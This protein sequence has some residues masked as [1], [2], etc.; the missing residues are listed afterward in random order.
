MI[1]NFFKILRPS[2]LFITAI[3]I[4]LSGSIFN[5]LTVSILPIMMVILLLGGFSNIINDLFDYKIDQEN[6]IRRPIASNQISFRFAFIFACL[7]LLIAILIIFYY[8]FNEL[9]KSLILF[10]N[11]PLIILY[12]PI[13]KKIPLI[14]N[15][16]IAFILG[17]VF[18][19]TTAYLNENI[20]V[21]LPPSILAFLLMLIREIVKD[22]A[23][24]SGDTKFNINTL[25]VRFGINIAFNVIICI[26]VIL[27]L[28]SIYFFNLYNLQYFISLL[29]LV[30]FP[31]IYYLYQ[32]SKNKTSTYCIY[33][34]KVLKLI[35]I[36]GV[37]V[38]YL[39]NI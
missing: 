18:V 31:L 12:T 5:Q 9:T 32:F 36:F 8:N 17:M 15:L 24:I 28:I 10:I 3:C 6:N 29:I 13:F 16:V 4:L 7:L 26:F 35:T 30:I 14:G 27:L 25:P 23:D 20:L 33:L 34:S 21:I 38:I 19:V 1:I 39:A 37:I 2:N 22:I 11:L